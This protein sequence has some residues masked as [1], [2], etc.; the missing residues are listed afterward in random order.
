MV[1]EVDSLPR[2]ERLKSLQEII[3]TSVVRSVFGAALL[4]TGASAAMAA[5]GTA[6]VAGQSVQTGASTATTASNTVA[7][8]TQPGTTTTANN[9]PI[10]DPAAPKTHRSAVADKEDP[11]GGHDPNSSFGIRAFWE[12]RNQY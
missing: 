12:D 10:A 8:T 7:V 1:V 2:P 3:M 6:P 11:Y 5:S 4:L 9:A